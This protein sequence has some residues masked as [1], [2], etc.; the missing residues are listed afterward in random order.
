MAK[1]DYLIVVR[2]YPDS[3]ENCYSQHHAAH[4]ID[5]AIVWF[6]IEHGIKGSNL[7]RFLNDN[8][9]EKNCKK[10]MVY[11]MP[12]WRDP[13]KMGKINAIRRATAELG[14]KLPAYLD[15]Y[16]QQLEPPP[17]HPET[18]RP[19]MKSI[20]EQPRRPLPVNTPMRSGDIKAEKEKNL[21]DF[22]KKL[23]YYAKLEHR[24]EGDDEDYNK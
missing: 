15:K 23:L 10:K 21:S 18:N 13:K 2:E 14:N 3:D 4:S 11:A 9:R 5:G 7:N 12:Y 1:R 19:E 16:R 17:N 8:G 20:P 24:G 6:A 22:A